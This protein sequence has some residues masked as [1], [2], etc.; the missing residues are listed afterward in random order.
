MSQTRK[1][2]PAGR[3]FT[4]VELL[5]V[6]AIIGILIA[7]LLP[8]VQAARERAR[9]THC[10]NNLKQLG[11]AVH[12]FESVHRHLPPPKLGTQFENR[13]STMVV[14]LPFLE[15]SATYA[16]YNLEA[17]IDDPANKPVTSQ[18]ISTYLCPSMA[19]PRSVPLTP[20]GEYLAPG[21]YVIS[22]RTK[23]SAHG[24]LDGAFANPD[25][26]RPYRLGFQ[27][28]KDGTSHTLLVGEID[29]GFK[30][31]LWSG[32]PDYNGAPR[33]GDTTWA[34]GYWYYAWGHVAAEFPHLFNNTTRYLNPYSARVFRSDH[35]GGVNFVMVDGSVT[36]L[37]TETTPE[38]RS[39]LVT[40]NGGELEH[41][42]GA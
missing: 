35:P 15:Q 1:A 31:F 9:R 14:L 4:L 11:I 3:G 23:Y 42:P 25:P 26:D 2:K 21:S 5:V 33:W 13:G 37:G 38:V 32:C 36:F 22:S 8:A 41:G 39:A 34:D 18:P 27:H 24:K 30:D 40:R 28:I 20:C 19:I 7:L 12:L 16:S 17:P 10:S 6:I 29:Y